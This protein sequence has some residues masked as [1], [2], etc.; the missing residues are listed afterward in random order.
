M[1]V[2][3]IIFFH[4]LHRF[5]FLL[6]NASIDFSVIQVKDYKSLFMLLFMNVSYIVLLSI[7]GCCCFTA[8]LFSFL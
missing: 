3:F 2:M 6:L 1:H 8:L 4:H 7:L 5:L